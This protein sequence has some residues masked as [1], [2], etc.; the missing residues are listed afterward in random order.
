M[1]LNMELE[2]NDKEEYQKWR[3]NNDSPQC[4][5]NCEIT[6]NNIKLKGKVVTESWEM[7]N[8]SHNGLTTNITF[9]EKLKFIGE[10]NYDNR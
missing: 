6:I 10:I 2:F 3:E 8:T 1:F 9:K 5:R 7:E 4:L